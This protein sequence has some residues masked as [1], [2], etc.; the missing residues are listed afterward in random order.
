[1]I[2]SKYHH[3]AFAFFMALFMSCIMSFIISVFNVGFV[4]DI[5]AIWLRAWGFAFCVGL[6]VVLLVSP[7]VR[8]LVSL[9]IKNE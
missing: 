4:S 7:T 1:M 9:V 2:N 8:R 6:P 5:V 3:F